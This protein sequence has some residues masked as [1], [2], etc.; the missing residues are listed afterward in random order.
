MNFHSF[1][2]GIEDEDQVNMDA[3]D[4]GPGQCEFELVNQ[5]EVFTQLRQER[6]SYKLLLLYA[7][8]HGSAL[9]LYKEKPERKDE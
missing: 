5:E 3:P 7:V 6:G 4:T 1:Q 9:S 2:P 8:L